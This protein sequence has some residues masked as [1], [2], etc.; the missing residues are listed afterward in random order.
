MTLQSLG[1]IGLRAKNIED[2]QSYGTRLLGMQVAERSASTL[3]LRMDDRK[4]RLIVQADGGEGAAF[5][6]FEVADAAALE[7]IAA[8][9]EAHGTGVA[10][11]ARALADERLVADL[12][13][14]NDPVGNRIEVFHGPQIAS[15]AFKPG[16]SISGFRTGPLGM[17]HVVITAARSD[18]LIPFYRD[19]LGFRLSDYF[20][21][22]VKIHFFH[23][24]PRH[25]TLGILET[26]SNG[27]HHMMVEV[28]FLDDV[29]QGYDIAQMTPDLVR[30]TMGRHINDHMT[31]FY[32]AN[33]SNFMVEYGWGGRSIEPDTW[34][35]TQ[36]VEGPSLWGHERLWLPPDARAEARAMRLKLADEG[37]RIPV[38]VMDG[39]YKLAPGTC[40]LWD[41]IGEARKRGYA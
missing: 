7:G 22:P 41:T 38:D 31:S 9:L 13:V 3:A 26:G 18:E 4:Q 8:R 40:V 23:L 36:V 10:R 25:H 12:I 21:R 27:I 2:W 24:N 1:Y 32:C 29:G 35:P 33:P 11:G 5:L 6:G 28:N 16:R 30:V 39:N 15:D 14:F 34:T 20:L 37:L 19:V 17:G